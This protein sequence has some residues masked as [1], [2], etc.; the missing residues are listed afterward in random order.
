MPEASKSKLK[1]PKG[2]YRKFLIVFNLSIVLSTIIL[3][4]G[5]IIT[6]YEI[7][8]EEFI[9]KKMGIINSLLKF[10]PVMGVFALALIGISTANV[11]WFRK[12]IISPLSTIED[13]V[14]A[15]RKGNFEK[16]IKLKTGDEFE[17]IADAFNQMMDKL[18]TLIQTEEQ[19]KEMQNNI[20]KF[21]QIM[22]QAAEGDLTQKAEVTPD[23]FGSLADAFNLMTDG[24]SE[25]VREVK[26]TA[27]DVGQ[28]SNILNEIIQKLQTGAEIQKQEIEKIVSLIEDASDI[29]L[30]TRDKTSAATDVSKE[31]IDAILKGN[32]IVTETINSMQLIRTAVQG[33]NRRMKLFSEKLMEI[34]TISTI[35]SDIANRTNLL[36]LNASIEAARAG[37][38]GKGFVVIAEEI[39]TLSE[40]TAK[41]SKNIADI[42]TAIQEEA[43]A[44]TKNLEEETNYVE[45]GTD[46]VNQTTEIFEK[47]DSIIKRIRQVIDDINEYTMKQKEITDKQVSSA[48][49]VKEVTENVYE[50]SHE[51]TDI[52]RSLSDTSK[53][54][55]NVTEKFRV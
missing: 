4:S 54:F 30:Q 24:L 37:E 22:T 12:Q 49:K 11:L 10:A 44:V 5:L 42:I 27:E 18:S 50:I 23:V 25:L 53:E 41:S 17:K 32:E 15:I 39:R 2:L 13:A 46:M 51:L 35:I 6:G 45:M 3:V 28:K 31:A 52:S 47:I 33:I 34:G 29:A 55:V 8:G 19:R 48:Q 20:I 14:E 40:K 36:A 38:E 21:L 7:Y 1:Q 16:R 9:M 26:N 43:T